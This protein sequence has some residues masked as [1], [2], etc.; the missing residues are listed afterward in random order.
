MAWNGSDLQDEFAE[1][2]NDSSTTFKA[3]VLG[4][5]NDIIV[6]IS[7]KFD[8]DFWNV[9]GKKVLVSGAD[10]QSLIVSPPGA[11][12]VAIAAG[13]SVT[14]GTYETAVTF[15]DSVHKI[16]TKKGTTSAQGVTTGAN[17]TINLTAVPVPS[18]TF[19]DSRRIYLRDASATT[20]PWLLQQTIS[21]ITTTTAS[22]TSLPAST[23]D[24]PPEQEYIK[25]I[26]GNLFLEATSRNLKYIDPK[27]I[28]AI[29][30][31]TISS[32]TP[33][34]WTKKGIS[35]VLMSPKPSS[36]LVLSFDFFRRPRRIYATTT[37][38][39]DIPREFKDVLEKGVVW[40]GFKYRERP[41][42]QSKLLEYEAA[43][44]DMISKMGDS[45][46]SDSYVRD[47]MG[48]SNGNVEV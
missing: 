6:D 48:D 38:E 39:P 24:Q 45:V 7:S 46:R 17:L 28:R 5:I 43:V 29:T 1:L 8:W 20:N 22:I 41:E 16:E 35:R 34:F 4:W 14:A 40:K 36:A 47:V 33:T 15:Y 27:Q 18:E 19:F 42:V 21:D 23:S 31:G 30:G 32:G 10:E 26:D 37:D 11:P 13:G 3:D 25:R 12:T 44:Q 9:K 2:L